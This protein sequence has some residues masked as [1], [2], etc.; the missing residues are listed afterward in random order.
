[1]GGVTPEYLWL[2][3]VALECK[4][5]GSF[6][7]VMR[8][9][10]AVSR[11]EAAAD[12]DFFVY[13]PIDQSLK[14]CRGGSS[15]KTTPSASS[16]VGVKPSTLA[17]SDMA[18]LGNQQALCPQSQVLAE[19]AD[20]FSVDDARAKCLKHSCSHFAWHVVGARSSTQGALKL[21]L[22]SGVPAAM[23]E[24]GSVLAVRPL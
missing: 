16:I 1:M 20:V 17:L 6:A 23:P 21:R 11:C 2:R 18:V 7:S 12:C 3:D 19:Y 22:C 24:E 9:H 5:V 13:A 8:I 15:L 10:E 4:L 14:L